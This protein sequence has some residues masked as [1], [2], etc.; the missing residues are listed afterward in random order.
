MA[1][2]K[3]LLT[4]TL[5]QGR[6][7]F[8]QAM[9]RLYKAREFASLAGVTVRALHHYDRIGV[10]KPRRGDSGYRLYSLSDLERLEQITALKF[11]GIPLREIKALLSASPLTLAES[12]SAQL[13][14]LSEK[15]EQIG[16]A[17]Q[18]IEAAQKLD[19]CDRPA[20]APVLR[21]I[22]EVIEM[23]PQEDFMQ[24]YY[25]EEAWAKR[26]QIRSQASAETKK[27][28]QQSWATLFL[29]VEAAL[30]LDTESDAVQRLAKRWMQ[31]ARSFSEGDPEV[32][33]G[34]T[35]AWKDREHWPSDRQDALL[36][37]FGLDPHTDRSAAKARL[38]RAVRF[39]GR[40]MVRRY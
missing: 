4:P 23:Q 11:L 24:K 28:H 8:W 13:G 6:P 19:R 31:L 39:I 9:N 30:D 21:K 32:W 2:G 16:R 29:E 38:E 10:L 37:A 18:A 14:A 27:E 26:N 20:D 22:I 7:L 35:E 17:I 36:A 3:Y 15:R 12:L 1:I 40:A 5:R 33:A 25:T 34:A